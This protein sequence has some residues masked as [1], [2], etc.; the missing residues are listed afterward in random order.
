M[1]LSKYN[2]IIEYDNKYYIYN[3]LKKTILSVSQDLLTIIRSGNFK[4]I[5]EDVVN[6]L[7]KN[8]ALVDDDVNE[9]EMIKY[10]HN[11]V[12]YDSTQHGYIIYPTLKCNLNCSY[13]FEKIDR[14]SIT[15]SKWNILRNFL[16]QK[17]L[18]TK[19]NALYLRW[20][21]GEPLLMWNKIRDLNLELRMLCNK[22]CIN[23]STSLCTNATLL[24]KKI[25]EE[26]YESNFETITISIDGPC[27]IHDKRRFYKSYK[28]SYFDV[29]NG[30]NNITEYQNVILRINIDRLNVSYFE[31]ML[32]E[33]NEKIINKNR[34]SIYLKP[35]ISA[36]NQN[37]N[38]EIISDKEYFLIEK[39]LLL[40]IADYKFNLSFDPFHSY[41]TRCI[42]YQDGSYLI[43]PEL[44][45][46]KC[47]LLLGVN[48]KS[49]GFIDDNAEIKLTNPLEKWKWINSNPFDNDECMN[50][51][52]L[53]L[54]NGKC[55]AKFEQ[56]YEGCI[57]ERET[58]DFRIKNFILSKYVKCL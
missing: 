58:L 31:K 36:Y 14:I 35:V 13:C 52:I 40:K 44:K 25:A 8:G 4:F 10:Y 5:G 2:H 3:T 43:D 57:S 6:I 41:Y 29:I 23:L 18:N 1:K 56:L 54:C 42:A 37:C 20:S 17:A 48:E 28:G 33:L 47:P 46:F 39:K 24:T 50:C 12:K 32:I 7:K 55:L 21:G 16:I 15:E 53:P 45:L 22:N 26:I 38:E 27:D 19:N 34:I 49:V 30:I 51:K 11:K 9:I